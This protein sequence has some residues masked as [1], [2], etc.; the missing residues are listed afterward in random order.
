MTLYSHS[1]LSTFEKCPYK[2]KL[3]YIDKIPPEIKKT[4]EAHLGKA[5][6]DTLEWLYNQVKEKTPTLD[7]TIIYYSEKW[8]QEFNSDILIV[9]NDMTAQDY[10]HKGVQFIID[11]YFKHQP[12]KDGTIECEKKVFLDLGEHKMIGFIDRLVQNLE[13]GEYEIHDYKTGNL[14]P[15]QEKIDAD[16][17]LALY[18][19]AIKDL[20]GQDKKVSL[21][22]HYL[23]HNTKIISHRTQEQLEQLKKDVL[24]LINKIESTTEFPACKST[25]CDWCEYKNQCPEFNQNPQQH[26][27]QEP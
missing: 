11:Y 12:F 3:K 14:L 13:T 21:V 27:S 18:S 22:W 26:P 24:E 4:I 1:K 2:F 10:Y 7:E 17:Q 5:V 16:R 15:S 6:H 20:F 19:I 25:L 9:R 23:A 8:Q